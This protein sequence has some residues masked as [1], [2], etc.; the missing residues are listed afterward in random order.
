MV[1][2]PAGSR[3]ASVGLQPEYALFRH[4]DSLAGVT[5]A[6]RQLWS[7]DLQKADIRFRHQR[8]CRPPR[9]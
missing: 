7:E 6:D 5:K 2:F 1:S 3:E 8:I 9:S 4:S